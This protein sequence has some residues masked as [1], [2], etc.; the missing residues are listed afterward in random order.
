VIEKSTYDVFWWSGSPDEKQKRPWQR[1]WGDLVEAYAVQVLAWIAERTGC[2]FRADINWNNKQIDAAMWFKGH[3]ALFEISAAML[4]DAAAHGG[5]GDKLAAGLTQILVRSTAL[6]GTTKDEAVA[7]V[8]RD[9]KAVLSGELGAQIPVENIQRVYPVVI[10]IDR[11]VRTPPLRFWFDAVFEG[12][13]AGFSDRSRVA[14]LAVW[15]LEDLEIMEQLA[16]DEAHC[17]KGTPR[18]P[19]RLLRDWELLRDK[20]PKTGRRAGA[21][22]HFV[23]H[24]VAHPA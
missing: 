16:R 19:L 2:G 10:A 21:W 11:R 4:T 23:G 6:T 24:Q 13:L 7:Q 9:S 12:E 8:A 3:V 1:D 18:G 17:L 15:G 5:H 22:R 14:A 20:L